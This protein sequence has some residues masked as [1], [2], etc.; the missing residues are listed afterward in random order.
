MAHP[1]PARRGRKP[2][3]TLKALRAKAA[4]ADG[5]ISTE[6][7][8]DD[9]NTIRQIIETSVKADSVPPVPSLIRLGSVSLP[10]RHWFSLLTF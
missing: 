3:T 9:E 10:F 1:P 8:F 6:K 4:L 7:D 5:A 2:G